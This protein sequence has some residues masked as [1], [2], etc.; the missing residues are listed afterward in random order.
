[1]PYIR[2]RCVVHLLL[3]G[4]ASTIYIYSYIYGTCLYGQDVL[5]RSSAASAEQRLSSLQDASLASSYWTWQRP[6]VQSAKEPAM[7]RQPHSPQAPGEHASLV[8][9]QAS[10]ENGEEPQADEDESDEEEEEKPPRLLGDRLHGRGPVSFEYVYTGEVLSNTRGG[11]RTRHG[12]RYE[13]LL[14]L[15][16]DLD[17]QKIRPRLPGRVYLLFQHTHG[18][19]L[20]LD[21]VGDA[22]MLSTIDSFGNITQVSEYWWETTLGDE[23]LT[24]RLGKQDVNREFQLVELATDFVHSA[25]G[26][27]ATL[28]GP[29]YPDNSIAAVLLLK[30]SESLTAKAGVWD[31][32]PN[33]AT[34]GF[35]NT[36]ITFTMVELER[37][38]QFAERL[39]GVI[40]FGFSYRSAINLPDEESPEQYTL[41]FDIE[42]MVYRENPDDEKDE[43][44]L[45]CFFRFQTDFPRPENEV[46]EYFAAGIVYRGLLPRRDDDRIGLAVFYIRHNLGGT[47]RE[48]A[49]E[50]FY[51]AQLTPWM[52]LQP[53]LQYISSPSGVYRDSLVAGLRFQVAF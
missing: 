22:Q 21:F 30:L 11:L 40:D 27:P 39:P 20:S 46:K 51:K 10:S 47:G 14:D 6:I 3:I 13:G 44:G 43:Q 41:Y 4:L 2:Q 53:V 24:I 17:L 26:I 7:E 42:Q 9:E 12:T 23:L 18:R 19:G 37:T 50:L 8:G 35:S 16:M 45:G 52:T 36:G 15:S 31:G 32:Y 28:A 33:G 1:M 5:A 25:A 48:T 34:W 49:T 29:T 38:H